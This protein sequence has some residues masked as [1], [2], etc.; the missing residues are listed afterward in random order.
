MA[1]KKNEFVTKY[2]EFCRE[3]TGVWSLR[4]YIQYKIFVKS[5]KTDK[6]YKEYLNS[7]SQDIT[8]T[9]NGHGDATEWTSVIGEYGSSKWG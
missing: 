8:P 9:S 6:L 2:W 4:K 5:W 7:W 1:V 3:E